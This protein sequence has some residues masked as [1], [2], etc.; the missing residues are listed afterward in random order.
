MWF[1]IQDHIF[2]MFQIVK[3]RFILILF[4]LTNNVST[5]YKSLT[6]NLHRALITRIWLSPPHMHIVGSHII[7]CFKPSLI[8]NYSHQLLWYIQVH[9][10]AGFN[11]PI[12]SAKPILSINNCDNSYYFFKI[13]KQ[14]YVCYGNKT[15]DT[16]LW[17]F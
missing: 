1:H 8:G 5:Q 2:Y 12:S 7:Y 10:S 4:D 13:L 9:L 14:Y 17:Y 3:D 15:C 6:F 16:Y 11:D